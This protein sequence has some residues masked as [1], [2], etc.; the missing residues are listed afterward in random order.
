M[1]IKQYKKISIGYAWRCTTR[2]C[3]NFKKY[4][5]VFKSSFFENF[6]L[7][8]RIILNIICKFSLKVPRH[9]I[10][11]SVKLSRT[12]VYKVIDGI[13]DKMSKPDFF[14]DKLGG[15]DKTIQIDETM[16]NYK[17]KSHRGRS[18]TNKT[19]VLCIVEIAEK[20]T[21]D[22]QNVLKINLQ[23]QYCPSFV[24]RFVPD[25]QYTQMMQRSIS[26]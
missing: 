24:D 2:S 3:T 25:Q 6:N 15:P 8:V 26:L 17:C 10:I 22:L 18:P 7:D 20:I 1:N 9:C 13:I 5:S 11:N 16:L 14:T 12:V 23:Q 19:D 21:R 4:F